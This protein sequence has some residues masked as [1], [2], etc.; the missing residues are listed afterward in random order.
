MLPSKEEG[1]GAPDMM[2]YCGG[3]IDAHESTQRLGNG[4]VVEIL[5]RLRI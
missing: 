3:V 2:S 5:G 4:D 1:S